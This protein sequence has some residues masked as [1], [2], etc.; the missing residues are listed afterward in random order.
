MSCF[1]QCPSLSDFFR[2]DSSFSSN[3][4]VENPS[5]G[6]GLGDAVRRVQ[7]SRYS[8]FTRTPSLGMMQPPKRHLAMGGRHGGSL[9]RP[10]PPANRLA[11]LR[12]PSESAP[13]PHPPARAATH[14]R[15]TTNPPTRPHSPAHSL[16][17]YLAPSHPCARTRASARSCTR[18]GHW[19]KP[20]C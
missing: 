19:V 17:H 2:A 13:A 1:F 9:R 15:P 8:L 14:W 16:P 4:I 5:S 20:A 7:I 6:T 10:M 18:K 12:S 11:D 3:S